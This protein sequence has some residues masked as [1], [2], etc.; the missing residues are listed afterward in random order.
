MKDLSQ[1]T[2]DE[3]MAIALGQADLSQYTDDE[4]TEIAQ[5]SMPTPS[6][7][8]VLAP[9]A[10]QRFQAP[11]FAPL[12]ATET[13]SEE[14]KKPIRYITDPLLWSLSETPITSRHQALMNLLQDPN[15]TGLGQI[16]AGQISP[17]QAI[18]G[19]R[20]VAIDPRTYMIPAGKGAEI[21]GSK[22]KGSAPIRFVKNIA[23]NIRNVKNPVQFAQNVRA[24]FFDTKKQVGRAFEKGIQDLSKQYPDRSIDLSDEFLG[25]KKA[26]DDSINNPGL[27][28]EVKSIIRR[29][30]NPKQAKLLQDLIK[31]PDKAKQLTLNQAQDIKVA[32]QQAPSIKTKLAQGKFAN[33]KPGEMELL[34]LLDDIRLAQ[35]EIFPEMAQVRAP[36]AKYM[37]NYKVVK[38]MFKPTQLLGKI[39]KGFGNEEVEAM[40]KAVL[41]E[42]VFNAIKGYRSTVKSIKSGLK[43][44]LAGVG[45]EA[46][47]R[48]LN[49]IS[50]Q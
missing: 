10:E 28:S 8:R 37:E 35:S 2:D 45:I 44:G 40:V 20:E 16:A 30:R 34:D 39:R 48:M 7:G 21:L 24:R 6:I 32:V 46:T 26:L 47:R 50:G 13:L 33:W 18:T 15:I 38:N 31:N 11:G 36:Y 49:K 1:Y 14:I 22:I 12:A 19:I 25:M 29:I 42:D 17:K 4:L 27:A 5:G 9:F 43:L 3:L 41:P 23:Q